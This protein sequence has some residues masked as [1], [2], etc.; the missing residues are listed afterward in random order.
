[1]KNQARARR[2]GGATS[3]HPDQGGELGSVVLE[4]GVARGRF[5]ILGS[6]VPE[7]GLLRADGF[8]NTHWVPDFRGAEPWDPTR[9]APFWKA[10]LLHH[11]AGDFICSP[12]FGPG[13]TIEGHDLP[14]HGWTANEA[15]TL[16]E[17][18]E[19]SEKAWFVS[20]LDRSADRPGL[21]FV[22]R[23]TLY[24][25][26]RALW[27]FLR[28]ENPGPLPELIN[29]GRHTT[30]GRPFLEKGCRISLCARSFETPERGGEFDDTGRLAIGVRFEGLDRAPLRRGGLVD[31]SVVPGM[32]G[33]TDF[34]TGPVPRELR[35]GWSALANPALGLAYLCAFSGPSMADGRVAAFEFNDL[36]MQYGGRPFTPWAEREGEPDRSFCLGTENATAAYANGLEWARAHPELMGAPTLVEVPAGGCRDLLYCAAIVE[37]PRDLAASPFTTLE[38]EKGN[39]LLLGKN[40]V[41]VAA[42][43]DRFESLVREG[44]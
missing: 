31:I 16:V 25:G 14:P 33:A 17:I 32:I 9:D 37:V 11:I 27:S 44:R 30:L 20:S 15:W 23:E 12:N 39:L 8:F 21:R 29:V 38:S 43:A 18:G 19:D 1:M 7:F 2:E 42:L 40:G 36:W 13:C 34:V 26:E 41:P 10:R 24:T 3:G 5:D 22:R 35:V 4:N 28:I 6:M